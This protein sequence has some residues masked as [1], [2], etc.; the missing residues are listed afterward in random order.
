VKIA[1][2]ANDTFTLIH[3]RFDMLLDFL[4]KGHHLIIFVP[5]HEH[6]DELIQLG[7]VECVE[8]NYD[9]TGT[10]PLNDIKLIQVYRKYLKQEKPDIVFAYNL[11]PVIYGIFAAH[12]EKIRSIYA[13]IPGAGFVFSGE[14]LKAKAIRVFIQRMYRQSLGWCKKV[15]FQNPDD[16][17]E[18]VNAN[19]I[20]I[21]KCVQVHGSGVNLDKFQLSILPDRPVFLFCSRLLKVKGI[22]EYCESAKNVRKKYPEVEFHVVGGYDENPTCIS[23]DE[24]EQYVRNQDIFYHGK[25]NDVRPYIKNSTVFV[26]PSYHR[27]GV[28]HAILEA[29][30][31]GRPIL[32]TSSVGCRETVKE[33]LN[34]FMV[35]P[36][37]AFALEQRMLWFIEHYEEAKKMGEESR[38]YCAEKFDVKRV[39]QIILETMEL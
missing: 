7:N 19:L 13:M 29:M 23:K 32:T 10:S 14:N 8:L 16:L 33:G 9:R 36:K 37:D 4:S 11:K 35:G 39:N 27:E 12:K 6:M 30:A 3:F 31:M 20:Q 21:E 28:P 5:D 17:Q 1:I 38:R 25:V 24:L 34:G 18:F 15:F 22:L 2:I 26:L